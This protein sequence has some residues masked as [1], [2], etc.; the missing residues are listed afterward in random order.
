M[1]AHVSGRRRSDDVGQRIIATLPVR[2]GRP[3]PESHT[4]V[5]TVRQRLKSL[6]VRP[7]LRDGGEKTKNYKMDFIH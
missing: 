3:E 1:C 5:L 7:H 2:A 4:W 6:L